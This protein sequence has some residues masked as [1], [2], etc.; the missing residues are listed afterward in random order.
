[1]FCYTLQLK[2]FKMKMN[3]GTIE[4]AGQIITGLVLITMAAS[5]TLGVWGWIQSACGPELVWFNC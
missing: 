3:E 5:G 1:V 4:R 2:E